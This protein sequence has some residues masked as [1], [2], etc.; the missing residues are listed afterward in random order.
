MGEWTDAPRAQYLTS[1]GGSILRIDVRSTDP[2]L[3]YFIPR[4]NPFYGN[5]SGYR[6]EILAFGFRNPWRM[7]F[8][9][10]KGTLWVGD[11]GLDMREEV[12][13]ILPG[14]NYGWPQMEG[15]ICPAPCDTSGE[16]LVL[17]VHE[18]D[19]S[20]GSAIIGG[21]VYRGFNLW[22]LI[23][24]YVFTDYTGGRFWSFVV[25]GGAPGPVTEILSDGPI[26]LTLGT[27][28]AGEIYAGGGD[29]LV[30]RLESTVTT[31]GPER[32]PKLGRIGA[33]YPNPF[34]RS[35]AIPFT[36]ARGARVSVTV[37]DVRGRQIRRLET[38]Q[39]GVGAHTTRWEGDDARGGDAPSGVYFVSLRADGA[40]VGRTRVVLV[41]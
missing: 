40:L 1:L 20:L 39:R 10:V 16:D 19:H 32:A 26:I 29:G 36:L 33:P 37:H 25:D 23:G 15:T 28:A 38:G 5:S 12:N 6:E 13:R 17:P 7:S 8:D 30:Y 2:G 34:A 4:D 18:Y 22:Q 35:T 3:N 31:V 11:V 27:D 21:H 14:R 9:P 41:R 24:H